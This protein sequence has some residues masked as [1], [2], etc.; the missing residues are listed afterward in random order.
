MKWLACFDNMKII[1]LPPRGPVSQLWRN[2][3]KNSKEKKQLQLLLQLYEPMLHPLGVSV[4]LLKREDIV[5]T[6]HVASGAFTFMTMDRIC[7]SGTGNPPQPYRH[8]NL[9]CKGKQSHEWV[10]LAIWRL[11]FPAGS[12]PDSEDSAILHPRM[13]MRLLVLIHQR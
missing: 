13:A 12:S 6:H 10:F 11:Q 8:G 5:D 2:W 7:G 1:S 9:S 3:F 4:P